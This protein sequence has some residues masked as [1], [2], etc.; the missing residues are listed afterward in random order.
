MPDDYNWGDILMV[1]TIRLESRYRGYGIGLLALDILVEHIAQVSPA[2]TGEGLL[3]LDP[4][5]MRGYMESADHHEVVQ[6]KLIQY[7]SLFGL[8]VLAREARNHSAFLGQC[9][10][11]KRPEI[12]MVVPHLFQ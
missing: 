10:I 3:V 1:N 12:R 11:Y 4:S 8:E 9:M 6:D 5:G 2:W 7:Y